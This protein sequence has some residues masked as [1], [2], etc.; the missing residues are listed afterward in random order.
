MKIEKV[1]VDT[2]TVPGPDL[3]DAS[4]R[5]GARHCVLVRVVTD[6]GIVGV[7]EADSWGQPEILRAILERKI[8]P[9][10]IGEDPLLIERLWNKMY[11][12]S[13]PAGH[14]GYGLAAIGGVD[15]AL[16]DILGKQTGTPVYRLLGGFNNRVETYAS[17]GFYVPYETPF[18]CAQELKKYVDSGYRRVKMKVGRNSDCQYW[19]GTECRVTVDGDY[20]R[21]RN[22]RDA[23]GEH[24]EIM[25]DV[26]RAWNPSRAVAMGQRLET[27]GVSVI[28]EPVAPQDVGGSIHVASALKMAVAGYESATDLDLC[29]RIISRGAVDIV[30]ADAIR[31]GGITGSYRVARMAHQYR[32]PYMPHNFSSIISTCANLHVLGA[33][34]NGGPL[35]WP[36]IRNSFHTSISAATVD[37]HEGFVTIPDAPGI[38]IQLRD[39]VIRSMVTGDA[40]AN[41]SISG[42]QQE[43]NT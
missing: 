33:C 30:Q 9:M 7:G 34:P 2:L 23:V 1:M 22:V 38:G 8:I 43:T 42:T 25:V 26:N 15:I 35:E 41:T 3:F 20:E 6:N 17:G 39:D 24:I 40:A 36:M 11:Q 18:D 12:R 19:D 10:L 29:N 21:V 32:L 4:H 31:A 37:P 14:T 28:E 5:L 13:F 27:L 16:W